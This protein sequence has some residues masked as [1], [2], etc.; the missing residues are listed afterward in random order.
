MAKKTS[1]KPTKKA[2]KP[3]QDITPEI[4]IIL[5]DSDDGITWTEF[6]PKVPGNADRTPRKPF[7]KNI[8]GE[9]QVLDTDLARMDDPILEE[10]H[11]VDHRSTLGTVGG[12][13]EGL[14]FGRVAA[15]R[16]WFGE[17]CTKSDIKVWVELK[18]LNFDRLNWTDLFAL[19]RHEEA[20]ANPVTEDVLQAISE[21]SMFDASEIRI[22]DILYRVPH[23]MKAS[24]FRG[25]GVSKN[26][27]GPRSV[28]LL[29]E[30]LVKMESDAYVITGLGRSFFE[31]LESF[32][33]KKR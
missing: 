9:L 25:K 6:D 22:L 32:E 15:I 31:W 3:T 27:I 5:R 20:Q 17:N 11:P 16:A 18:G 30:N 2:A 23:K 1:K 8:L 12:V 29:Q 7:D 10:R 24:Q 26:T 28:K 33:E 13:Q 14:G 19:K 21:R 4:K